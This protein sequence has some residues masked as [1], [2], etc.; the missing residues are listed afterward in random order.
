MAGLL[1]V[2]NS[3]SVLAVNVGGCQRGGLREGE[4]ALFIYLVRPE[5][6]LVD[7]AILARHP[8]PYQCL[9]ASLAAGLIAFH[10]DFLSYPVFGSALFL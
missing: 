9:A 5:G 10:S 1:L 2:L 3:I 7:L 6:N 8:P 4:V